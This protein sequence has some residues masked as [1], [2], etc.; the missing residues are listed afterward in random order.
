MLDRLE[1]S[2]TT[3][4]ADLE[5]KIDDTKTELEGKIDAKLD[6]EAEINFTVTSSELVIDAVPS[7][8]EGLLQGTLTGI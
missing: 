7:T 2:V 8:V 5:Q 4:K 6:K 3:L 1:Q